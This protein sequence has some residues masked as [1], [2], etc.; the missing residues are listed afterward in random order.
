MPHLL[1]KFKLLLDPTT[2]PMLAERYDYKSDADALAAGAQ[3]RKDRFGR[4]ALLTIFEW[5]TGGRGRSR[6]KKNSDQEIADALKL[7]TIAKTDR[8]ALAVLMGLNGIG[9]PVASA[10]LTAIDPTRFTIV[11]FRALESLNAE[12]ADIT[13][14]FYLAYLEECRR[15]AREN[16]VSLRTLDQALWQWSKEASKKENRRS[17]R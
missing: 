9:V 1:P 2:I 15:L 13:I 11:D 8:A 16:K 4:E 5:K 12:K 7:A 14:D 3:I 17:Q 6:L 10:I